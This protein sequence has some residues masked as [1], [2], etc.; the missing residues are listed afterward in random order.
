M[1]TF[2]ERL[3]F[4]CDKA[5]VPGKGRGRGAYLSHHLG[6]SQEGVRKWLELNTVPRRVTCDK[7]AALLNCDPVW[8][9]MGINDAVIPKGPT[10]SKIMADRLIHA[11]LLLSGKHPDLPDQALKKMLIESIV[12]SEMEVQ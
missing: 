5:G 10:G 7:I 8:L 9:Y 12:F 4:A 11:L 1:K 2:R 3:Q 6:V